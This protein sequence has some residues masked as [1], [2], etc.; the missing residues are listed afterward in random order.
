MRRIR[1]ADNLDLLVL[2]STRTRHERSTLRILRAIVK[3]STSTLKHRAL[4]IRLASPHVRLEIVGE[5]LL[6]AVR[7]VACLELGKVGTGSSGLVGHADAELVR[8][9]E[10][11]AL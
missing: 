1:A 4:L 9:D 2:D 7:L 5:E 8:G 11:D 6:G 3:H 10:D